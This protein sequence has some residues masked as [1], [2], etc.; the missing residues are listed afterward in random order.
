MSTRRLVLVFPGLR[1]QSART[2]FV[3]GSLAVH[4]TLALIV[5]VA[6]SLGPRRVPPMDVPIVSLAGSL[7]TASAPSPAPSVPGPP[8]PTPPVPAPREPLKQ[9]APKLRDVPPP[10]KP[11]KEPAKAPDPAPAPPLPQPPQPTGPIGGAG[12]PGP[13][14]AAAGGITALDTGDSEFA[15]YRASVIAALTARWTRP[16][17]ED[18]NDTIAATVAF[19]IRRDGTVS[20]LRV[21]GPSG[22]AVMDR[23]VL[24]AVIEAAP[25]PPLPPSWREP[26]LSA[27]FEF[28][29]RPG[30]PD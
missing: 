17:I 18:T 1:G 29:W 15:W 21:E 26:T 30:E 14:G 4:G 9:P 5:I 22:V 8:A 3:G 28:R 23:S 7:P 24:R 16:V 19:D 13:A 20:N 12:S 6:P 27:R 10:A 11:K 25:L 2:W